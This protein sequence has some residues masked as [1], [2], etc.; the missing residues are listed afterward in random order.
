M[1]SLKV[2]VAKSSITPPLNVGLLTSSVEGKWAPFISLRKPL[3]ARVIILEGGNEKIIIVALD[4][5]GLTATSTGGWEKFKQS[6]SYTAAP[7]KIIIH[8]THTHNAPESLALT[9]LYK[10]QAYIEWL[11]S[12][13][14]T[15]EWCIKH[16]EACMQNCNLSYGYDQLGYF[17]LQRRIP[18]EKGMVISDSLQPISSELFKREPADRRI[19]ALKFTKKDGSVH[20]TI[21]H[22]VC[23]P[24]NEMCIP[25]ISPDYPGE[26]CRTLEETGAYG[27]PVFLNGA[28]GDINPPTVSCGE[29]YAVKQGNAIA[30][31]VLKMQFNNIEQLSL[32]YFHKSFELP[33]RNFQMAMARDD[34]M[35]RINIIVLGCLVIVFLPGEPFVQTGLEIESL[36]PFSHTLVVGYSEN[37]VGYIPPFHIFNEG[38]YETGPGKWSYLGIDSEFMI[39]QNVAAMLLEASRTKI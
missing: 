1:Y 8:C 13:A 35:T 19:R 5:L 17:S 16:A 21:V 12:V 6:L 18:T 34:Y 33:A 29:E 36:S 39:K 4:L 14:S 23:H 30:R 31:S 26:L 3:M 9:D 22:A 37:S 28:A 20:A 25:M 38:G 2:G 11:K 7:A 15:I 10:S 24:V 27:M 32:N